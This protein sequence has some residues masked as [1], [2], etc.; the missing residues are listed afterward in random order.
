M[1]RPPIEFVFGEPRTDAKETELAIKELQRSM[2]EISQYLLDRM[3]RDVKTKTGNYTMDPQLDR[4]ILADGTSGTVAITLPPAADA[5]HTEYVIKAINVGNA[6]TVV[7]AAAAD[8]VDGV[9]YS[10]GVALTPQYES[11]RLCSDGTL[12]HRTDRD[13]I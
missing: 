12:W 11:I 6:V 1:P 4:I 9:D 13:V 8:E 2:A 5:D 10:S 7:S 3:Y